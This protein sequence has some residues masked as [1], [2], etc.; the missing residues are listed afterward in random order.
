M[1]ARASAPL[2]ADWRLIVIGASAGGVEAMRAVLAQLPADLPAALVAI[3]HLAPTM[4]SELPQI[5]ARTSSMPTAFVQDG[6]PLEPGRLYVAP[7]DRHVLVQGDGLCLSD[8]P[9]INLARP[10]IDPTF[11]S[12]AVAFGSRVIGVVLSGYL[13]DGADGL[14]AIKRCGGVAIV[15]DP[16]DAAYPDMP[17][18][19][20]MLTTPDHRLPLA[21]MGTILTALTSAPLVD[22]AIEPPPDIVDEVMMDRSLADDVAILDRWGQ[23]AAIGCPECG[24]PMWAH[25]GNGR[26]KYRCHIGHALS[27][28]S[29]LVEQSREIEASLWV[30][31]RTLEERARV[32][33]QL[34][35]LEAHA[36]G[37]SADSHRRADDARQQ[38]EAVKRLIKEVVG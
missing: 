23:K 14:R 33:G 1:M 24:G 28:E 3:L 29:L 26:K 21:Q 37:G 30:A 34:N 5:L 15:Q 12:A 18:N 36:P 13:D 27:F 32:L 25:G 4:R 19:A 2:Q 22:V 16:D 35:Q 9:R 31:A 6:E 20:M 38:A 7:P 17:R 10:A 8:G 11:R